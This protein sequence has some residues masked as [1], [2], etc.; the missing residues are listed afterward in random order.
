M[1][2]IDSTKTEDIEL[3]ACE[4]KMPKAT[5]RSAPTDSFNN[6]DPMSKIQDKKNN[7]KQHTAD[8]NGLLEKLQRMELWLDK[9]LGIETQGIDR[10]PEEDKAPPSI[11]NIFLM[12]W[13]LTCHV[14]SLP[15]GILGP[16]F[17]L[18]LGQCMAAIILGAFLGSSCSAS[19]GTL[20]PKLGLRAIATARYSFG[21][22]GANICSLL[23]IITG[24]GYATVNAVVV[25]QLL[26]SVTE[27]KLSSS[28]GCILIG[29]LSYVISI[30]GFKVIHSYVKYAWIGSFIVLCILAGQISSKVDVS[31]PPSQKGLAH[32]G[33]FLSFLTIN[34][35]A[36]ATWG[37]VA[38]DYFCYYP[39][40]T[41]TWKIYFLMIFGIV[42]PTSFTAII[43]ACLGNIAF[44]TTS[45]TGSKLITYAYPTLAEAYRDYGLG[46]I[47]RASYYPA[48]L[49]KT[50]LT[51]LSFSVLANNIVVNYSVGLSFQLFGD[52]F[53]AVPRFIWSFLNAVLI[54]V[55]AVIGRENLSNIVANFVSMLGYWAISFTLILAIEDRL[56]RRRS[57]YNLDFWN[58][59]SKLPWGIS[60]IAALFVSYLAGALSGMSQS[61]YIGPIARKFGGNGGDVGVALSGLFTLII[62]P[63]VRFYE[64][65]VY[66]K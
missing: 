27:H 59:P 32:T 63:I 25:G 1:A 13:S 42:L 60:A 28:I 43:G 39:A 54:T 3:S 9:K 11:I 57:G 49:S 37:T 45:E 51:L 36:S 46:G 23:N 2:F 4:S 35:S 34:F 48:A 61:L 40:S 15:M 31:R 10:V 24:T 17:G 53:H 16:E 21:F 66:G 65:K 62:Y 19:C 50:I 41:P 52:F 30:F 18:T 44:N 5:S 33:A 20:G 6:V 58:T 47:L 7:D 64:L 8:S 12:W 38:A 14:G 55:L 29:I 26:S 56:F 22:Y